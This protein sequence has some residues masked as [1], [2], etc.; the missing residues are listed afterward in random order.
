ME[1]PW[2]PEGRQWLADRL[3]SLVRRSGLA[4]E[5]RTRRILSTSGV[6]GVLEEITLLESDYVRRLYYRELLRTGSLDAATVA[7]VVAR[8]GGDIRS[9]YE[10]RQTLEAAVPM[11][12]ADPVAVRAYIEATA[13]MSSGFEHRQALDA[14]AD[15]DGLT[16][17]AAG[18]IAHSA[19]RIRS[20]FEKRQALSQLLGMRLDGAESARAILDA[21]ATIGSDYECAT[22]LVAFV[23]A[24]PLEGAPVTAFFDAV[25]TIGS[26]YERGRVLKAVARRK[27]LQP[28]ALQGV[29]AA[30]RTM[31]SDFEQAQ[32]LLSV[33]KTHD[34][35]AASRPAFLAAADTIHS[36]FEQTPGAGRPR[37]RRAA[38]T[39]PCVTGS[40]YV[41]MSGCQ[42]L[43]VSVTL[44]AAA[45]GTE[46]PRGTLLLIHAF[47]LNARMW[48][49]QLALA[50]HGW[51]VIAPQ[52]R[53]VGR[54]QRRSA[55]DVDGRLRGRRHRPARCAARRGCGHRRA[56]DGRVRRVRDVASRAALYPGARARRHAAA[57]RHARRAS[58]AAGRCSRWSVRRAPPAVADEMIPKLLG[59][60]TRRT[61][62][63]VADRVRDLILSNSADAIAAPSP[64]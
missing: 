57:G 7:R 36:E 42:S 27:P 35:D 60:H 56:V 14:L 23:E 31:Q 5:S 59:E 22:F 37:S 53:G 32:V 29:F 51:R 12:A 43:D 55:R 16:G 2:D 46:R 28:A 13:S 52:L 50:R 8:A 20:D 33:V 17:G 39:R 21:A 45:A 30:V 48:E 47:P 62:P 19:A 54:R 38:I 44:E 40:P 3:P 24:H 18:Q 25:G 34:I 63:D 58:K 15:A 64:R 41:T 9:D 10:L 11:V 61:R 49:P 1:Q 6:N 4:V 26:D